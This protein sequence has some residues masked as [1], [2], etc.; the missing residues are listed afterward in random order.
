[1]N[2]KRCG[3]LLRE[4]INFCTQCGAPVVIKKIETYIRN[5]HQPLLGSQVSDQKMEMEQE[6]KN[7]DNIPV[8]SNFNMEKNETQNIISEQ[9]NMY[10]LICTQCGKTLKK[11]SLFCSECGY[12]LEENNEENI[13]YPAN[14]GKQKKKTKKIGWIFIFSM[15]TI[16]LIGGVIGWKDGTKDILL[17]YFQSKNII[18]KGEDEN[19]QV[20][21]KEYV[22]K[23]SD[24]RYLSSE[25]LEGF[26]PND[27][28]L[29]RNEIF[30]RHGMIFEDKFS[31]EYFENCTW[32]IPTT[33]QVDF[34]AEIL[35]E[36]EV[37]NIKCIFEYTKQMQFYLFDMDNQ[38][39]YIYNNWETDED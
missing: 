23:D 13:V 8:S 7:K 1:M 21:K 26:T 27:C 36:Y 32:Y 6:E 14:Q 30:A 5:V 12:K 37:E 29:A 19:S 16:I 9:E 38:L 25:E 4:G 28:V 18:D 10:L 31:K 15:M 17:G 2:C 20:T 34:D 3:Y 35:N 22:I 39:E 33:Q 11:D 24:R